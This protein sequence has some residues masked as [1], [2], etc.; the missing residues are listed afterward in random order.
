M[1]R[2][3]DAEDDKGK[4]LN[5]LGWEGRTEQTHETFHPTTMWYCVDRWN[6][7]RIPD[8]ND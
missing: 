7:S 3:L 6:T 1:T 5:W 2:H 8:S 4:K